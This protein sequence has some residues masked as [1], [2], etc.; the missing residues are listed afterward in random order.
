MWKNNE[1]VLPLFWLQIATR[2]SRTKNDVL[3]NSERYDRGK[4]ANCY[5]F[6]FLL[7]SCLFFSSS[8]IARKNLRREIWSLSSDK[9]KKKEREKEREQSVL[10]RFTDVQW[11]SSNPPRIWDFTNPVTKKE[12]TIKKIENEKQW[13]LKLTCRRGYLLA[14]LSAKSN[15]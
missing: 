2:F 10:V 9:K 5:S 6:F 12:K 7:V 11:F 14:T 4:Y 1:I 13:K 15:R 8:K 3:L